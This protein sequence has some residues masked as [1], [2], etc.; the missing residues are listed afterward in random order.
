M[1]YK[2]YNFFHEHFYSPYILNK[3]FITKWPVKPNNF[4]KLL[5][6]ILNETNPRS[7]LELG[8][9]ASTLYFIRY[10][11]QNKNCIFFSLEHHYLWYRKQLKIIKKQFGNEF[12]NS[13]IYSKIEKDWY[14]FKSDKNFE[15]IFLDGPNDNSFLK[16]NKSKRDSKIGIN[17]LKEKIEKSKVF[18]IDDIHREPEK[19]IISQ[20]NIK[21]KPIK[22]R[23]NN[24]ND[25][26]IYVNEEI[27][28]K[29]LDYFNNF[30]LSNP[31]FYQID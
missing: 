21:L 26:S 14:D 25:I 16:R 7:I 1:I 2:F 5:E 9:G 12:C 18:I 20:L 8:S 22:F 23:Y 19:N 28:K 6:F 29:I 13:I 27:R 30:N 15:F 31:K 17:F 10:I 11:S 24:T 4:W 3:F